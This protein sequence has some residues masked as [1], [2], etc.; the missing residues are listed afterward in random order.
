MFTNPAQSIRGRGA[1]D[2][3]PNRFQSLIRIP[4]PD[5][6][7]EDAVA[8]HTQF[9]RDSSKS[10]LA[11]NDS[12][13][14]PFDVSLNPYRGCEHGCAYCFARPTH[15]YLGWSAGLDFETRIMV[16]EDAPELL[17]QQFL[18]KSWRP[19]PIG[20]GTVTDVYQ[21]VERRL[22]ITRR[23]LEVFLRFRNPVGIVTKSALISRDAD[24]LAELAQFGAA[25]AFV[26]VTTLDAELARKLEP[27]AAAP[28][29]RLRTVEEL[30]RAGVPVAV[31]VAPVIPGLTDHEAP[32]ILRAVADA[33]AL[34][35]NYVVLRLPHGVKDVFADWLARHYPAGGGEKV[36]G[37][38]R[39]I[40]GG[41]LNDPRFG[42]RMRG[43][44]EWAEAFSRLFKI[45]RRKVGMTDSMPRLSAAHFRRPGQQLTLF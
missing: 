22:R 26:S 3:P 43:E 44:G 33:G 32:A 21:P 6:D 17:H 39:D 29:A 34:T 45:T 18:A 11:K 28:A 31:M 23:C 38:I 14:I 4:L 42:T 19:Q 40:R 1:A 5:A 25:A 20:F 10:I 30:R 8:P 15:E 24:L 12:P 13:D 2:N 27:R 35:A 36:L 41:R 37:R 16:K 9:F 7:A